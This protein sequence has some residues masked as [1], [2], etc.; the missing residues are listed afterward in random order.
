MK[1]AFMELM[2]QIPDGYL[3]YNA[4]LWCRYGVVLAHINHFFDPASVFLSTH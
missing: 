1:K 4:A 2:G 3:A